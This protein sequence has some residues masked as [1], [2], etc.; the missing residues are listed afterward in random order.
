MSPLKK[1]IM[2]KWLTNNIAT[3]A[4]N[5]VGNISLDENTYVIDVR[6]LVDKSGNDIT[7]INNKINESISYLQNEKKIIICCDYGMSRSNSIA[8]G[9]IVK[10]LNVS[11]EKA[12]IIAQ[13]VV[14]E[15]GIKIEMFNTVYNTLYGKSAPSYHSKE[16][17]NILITGGSGFIGQKLKEILMGDF[18]ISSPNSKELNLIDASISLFQLIKSKSINTIIHLAN[19]NIYTTNKSIGDTIVMLKNILDI[20]RTCNVKLIYLSGWEIY[21]GYKSNVLFANENITPNPKGTYG[22]TKWLC[23]LLI[24]QYVVNYGIKHLIIRSGPV[25]GI[26]GEKPKFIYNFINK[27]LKNEGIVTH[28]YKNGYPILDLLFID[29]LIDAIKKAIV[30]NYV[31]EI[32]VGSGYGISTFD[33]ATIICDLTKSESK[34]THNE[35]QEYAPNIIMDTQFAQELLQWKPKTDIR[36]G[37]NEILNKL[38]TK[39]YE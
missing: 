36:Y 13:N 12:V 37:L 20:C 33:I 32:N 29:D 6:D 34:I 9:V 38:K 39:K 21:S 17:N 18:V 19:P 25:Y 10:W 5:E 22:E 23:E 3:G 24:K 28:R 15:S 1:S 7:N 26:N 16:L 31:G 8:I 14:D 35:I 30:S 27:A 2:I 4:F 11:F